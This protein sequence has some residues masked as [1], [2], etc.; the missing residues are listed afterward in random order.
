M[1][2]RE[3]PAGSDVTDKVIDED[4]DRPHRFPVGREVECEVELLPRSSPAPK[5]DLDLVRHAL[6]ELPAAWRSDQR[7]AMSVS[8]Q[9]GGLGEP[10]RQRDPVRSLQRADTRPHEEPPAEALLEGA[11]PARVAF[12]A[13]RR[14][15]A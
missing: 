5:E 3:S 1:T 2:A 11:H 12:S 13:Y 9:D 15:H 6:E 14:E 10:S 4:R 7:D 8:E